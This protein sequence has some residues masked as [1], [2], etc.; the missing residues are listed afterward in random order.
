ME[1]MVIL[2]TGIALRLVYLATILF[3]FLISKMLD[4]FDNSLYMQFVRQTT[5]GIGMLL[6]RR[7]SS[8]IS[9]TVSDRFFTSQS[10]F[11]MSLC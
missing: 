10:D 5:G 7:G 8:Y 4:I 9:F 1:V 2:N 11:V 3:T 6:D